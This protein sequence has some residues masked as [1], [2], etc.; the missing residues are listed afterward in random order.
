VIYYR[1]F[2]MVHIECQFDHFPR[3]ML[4]DSLVQGRISNKGG[5]HKCTLHCL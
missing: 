4:F 5:Y 1:L 2:L 3:K